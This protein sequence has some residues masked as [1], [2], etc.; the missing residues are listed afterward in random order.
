MMSSG[1]EMRVLFRTNKADEER[2]RRERKDERETMSNTEENQN[3]NNRGRNGGSK[4]MKITKEN[5]NITQRPTKKRKKGESGWVVEVESGGVKWSHGV[6]EST[7][8]SMD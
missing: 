6:T 8:F 7:V 1:D 2:D 5:E 4:T 3:Q